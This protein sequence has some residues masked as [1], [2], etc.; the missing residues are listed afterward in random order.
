MEKGKFFEHPMVKPGKLQLR[1]YQ[2]SI[3][4]TARK[5][6]TLCVLPTGLGKT[7]IAMLLAIERMRI[8]GGKVLI[9]APTK[10]LVNQHYKAFLDFLNIDEKDIFVLTGE[11]RP[12]ERKSIYLDKK[13]IFATPQ[14]IQND[15]RTGKMSFRDFSLL[16]LDEIHHAIGGYAYP[17]IVSKYLEQSSD[18]RILGL[19]ASPG[20]TEEKIKEICKNSGIEA[21][22]IRTEE[23]IDVSPWVKEK[24]TEW[25]SIELPESFIKIKEVLSEV[26]REKL[27]KLRSRGASRL[28]TKRDLLELQGYLAK[29]ARKGNKSAFGGLFLAGQ[30]IKL[31]H[32][33]GLLETQGIGVLE[34]YWKKLRNDTTKAGKALVNDN[35]ISR[36]MHMTNELYEMGSKH[37]K[38]SRLCSIVDRQIR[39]KPGSRII[40]FANYRDS[41]REIYDTLRKIEAASPTMLIGQKEGL[42]QK[43]QIEIIKEFESGIHNCLITT[44]IGEEGLHLSSADLA[45]FYE[46]V[47]S[48]V[49]NIQRKGRVGRVKVGKIII[50]ITRG[51]RD[52]AY[53]W[54]AHRKEKTMKKTLSKLR[55][56]Y[57]NN[58]K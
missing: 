25:V 44:S 18:P 15:L 50:L 38:I 58:N 40:I 27:R 4:E 31:E 23:D 36:A 41:V 45:I 2:E 46:P 3:L 55:D 32:S 29:Q 56:R 39:S 48:E 10:P 22:E 30:A 26:Y 20:G 37:P 8:G 11:I 9:L 53:Y 54:T 5:K 1:D 34:K 17:Y 6:N 7:G 14:T 51:T 35:R 43:E 24:N 57:S 47:P 42:S 49:R 21:V 19:T 33:I 52:E 12:S 13:I 16:V 28:R